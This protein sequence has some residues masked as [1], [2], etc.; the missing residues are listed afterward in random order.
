MAMTCHRSTCPSCEGFGRAVDSFRPPRGVF[1][2]PSIHDMVERT[3]TRG[4][5]YTDSE[6]PDCNGTG[7]PLLLSTTFLDGIPLSSKKSEGG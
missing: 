3:T 4:Y 6:C 2:T 1:D 5:Y 7:S